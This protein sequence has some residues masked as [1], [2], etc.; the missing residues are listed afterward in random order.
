MPS[1]HVAIAVLQALLGWRLS[2]KLGLI[3]TGYAVIVLLG[4]VHLAWHYAVDG[5][6][7]I[8][9]ALIVWKASGWAMGLRPARSWALA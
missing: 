6:L 4:S 5:Y 3:L 2:R 9:L 8:L 7:S 1:L